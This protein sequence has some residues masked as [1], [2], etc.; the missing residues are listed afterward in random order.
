LQKILAVPDGHEVVAVIPIGWPVLPLREGPPRKAVS[1][2]VYLNAF[3][4]AMF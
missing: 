1:E 4:K 3:G 2:I